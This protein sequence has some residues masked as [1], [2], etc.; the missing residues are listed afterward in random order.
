MR[1]SKI[2]FYNYIRNSQEKYKSG[3][4]LKYKITF[5]GSSSIEEEKTISSGGISSHTLNDKIKKNIE[6]ENQFKKATLLTSVLD[7][8]E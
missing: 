7:D 4:K 1:T 8:N 6:N 3:L 2:N 5:E